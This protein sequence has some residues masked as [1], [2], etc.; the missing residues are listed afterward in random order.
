MLALV[1]WDGRA[2]AGDVPMNPANPAPGM[3]RGAWS[4]EPWGNGGTVERGSTDTRKLLKL[5]YSGGD[6]DKTA[7]KHVTCFGI[8]PKGKL[9]LHAYS[10]DDDAPM[11]ALSLSTTPAY[12]W[13]ESKTVKLKKGWNEIA[14][15]VGEKEWKTEASG[16]KYEVPVGNIDDIRAV[17]L[18]VFAGKKQG[19]IYVQG[20]SYDPDETGKKIAALSTDLQSEEID[21]RAAAEKAL[22]AIGRS[23]TEALYQ[24]EEDDRP[25]VMLR[26]AS[27]LRR[28]EEVKEEL[29]QDPE[30]RAEILK[31]NEEVKFEELRRNAAYTRASLEAQSSRLLGFMKEAQDETGSGRAKL[32]DMKYVDLEKRKAYLET[33][34]K[35]DELIKGLEPLYNKKDAKKPDAMKKEPEAP[36]V[37]KSDDAKSVKAAPALTPANPATPAMAA[38]VKTPAAMEKK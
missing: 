29:P 35:I 34:D 21:K 37:A 4:I 32:D 31:Q 9:I 13:H 20:I 23:A 38:P 28:I 18:L 26:A 12:H 14:F 25:E 8:D 36:K 15:P 24:I 7:Y 6:K 2:V 16:W 17:D 22:I 10:D 30:K 11:I 27:A 1:V 5:I 19:L 3:E 33:L